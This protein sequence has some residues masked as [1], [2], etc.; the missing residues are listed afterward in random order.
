MANAGF[1]AKFIDGSTDNACCGYC[2]K[3]LDGWE[4]A[5]DPWEEHKSHSPT[6]PLAN[7]SDPINRELTFTMGLWP[8]TKSISASQMAKAGFFFW[9][10]GEDEEDDTAICV[11][12]GLALDGWEPNDDPWYRIMCLLSFIFIW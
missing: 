7:L 3:N 11:Q 12:C 8:H 6:C 4:P 10:R 9:P 1:F 5:D 2:R